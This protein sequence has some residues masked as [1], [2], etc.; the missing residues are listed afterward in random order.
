M[1]HVNPLNQEEDNQS[2]NEPHGVREPR[3]KNCGDDKRHPN[4]VWEKNST[5]HLLSLFHARVIISNLTHDPPMP[6]LKANP[7][8]N[9]IVLIQSQSHAPDCLEFSADTGPVLPVYGSIW[10]TIS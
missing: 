10:I 5:R 6:D 7:V 4:P 1:E 3:A 2:E 9:F 8:R